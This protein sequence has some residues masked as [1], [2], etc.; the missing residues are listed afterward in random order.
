MLRG[1][2][3]MKHAIVAVPPPAVEKPQRRSRWTDADRELLRF[4][5][6]LIAEFAKGAPIFKRR[7]ELRLFAHQAVDKFFDAKIAGR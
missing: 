4:L 2:S 7:A 5:R 1:I 6:R 3:K